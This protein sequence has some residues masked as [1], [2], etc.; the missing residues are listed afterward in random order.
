MLYI[1]PAAY[2]A[3]HAHYPV[4]RIFSG[5]YYFLFEPYF[6]HSAISPL[7]QLVISRYPSAIAIEADY[8]AFFFSRPKYY[9]F[10]PRAR[11]T[12]TCNCH[13]ARLSPQFGTRM[14]CFPFWTCV[15]CVLAECSRSASP[16]AEHR[17]RMKSS[18]YTASPTEAT[19]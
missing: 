7:T 1:P 18:L 4:T 5:S 15:A 3:V 11:P 17:A 13:R 14:H 2:I 19:A 8:V 16:V 6:P 10:D 12:V 9:H